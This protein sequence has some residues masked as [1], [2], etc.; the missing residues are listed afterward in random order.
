[1]SVR[2]KGAL[3]GIAGLATLVLLSPL[4][5]QSR[6]TWILAGGLS[7]P[8]GEFNTFAKVGWLGDVGAEL[9][10]RSQPVSFR[11]DA[12]IASNSHYDNPDFE[13]KTRLLGANVSF[14]YRVSSRV[15]HFYVLAGAGFFNDKFSTNDPTDDSQ[16]TG[17]QLALHEGAGLAVGRGSV[18]GFIEGRY[19]FGLINGGLRFLPLTAGLRFTR[20]K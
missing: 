7:K 16:G 9:A 14:V 8:N 15:L 6:T 17:T 18:Q 4:A 20:R 2:T 19:V 13:D 3:F 12:F 5:A 10:L 1:M 11:F